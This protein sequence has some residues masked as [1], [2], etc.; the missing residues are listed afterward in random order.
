MT[1]RSSQPSSRKNRF[2]IGVA[3]DDGN[4]RESHG[5]HGGGADD[6]AG[7][8][9]YAAGDDHLGDADRDDADDRDLENDDFQPLLVEK[10]VDI[11]AGVEQEAVADDEAAQNFKGRD[12]EQQRH[13]HVEF[14]RPRPFR[15]I[16]LQAANTMGCLC[17]LHP[18]L[19]GAS[20]ARLP[21]SSC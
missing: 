7:G 20:G 4:L 14:R 18:P 3:V 9:V 13:K 10:R 6:G 19:M 21:P 12:D 11:F 17:H 15:G 2:R 5:D 16:I 1:G 8:Q